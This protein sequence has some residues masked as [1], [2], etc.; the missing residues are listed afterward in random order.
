MTKAQQ[1]RVKSALAS[2]TKDATR[3]ATVAR[4]TLVREGIYSEDGKLAPSY[5]EERKPA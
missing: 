3:S 2:Y 4:A 5:S 1:D